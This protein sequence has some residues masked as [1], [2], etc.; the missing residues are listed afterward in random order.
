MNDFKMTGESS[1]LPMFNT[2]GKEWLMHKERLEIL[3]K[4]MLD[5]P[6]SMSRMNRE[7]AVLMGQKFG[8]DG[9]H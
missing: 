2:L 5:L 8:F 3:N 1:M 6:N 9:E 4:V 7:E